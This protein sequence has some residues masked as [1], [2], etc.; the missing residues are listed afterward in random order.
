MHSDPVADM[1]T[2]IRNAYRARL[3]DVGIPHSK[4]LER[5]AEILHREGF[6]GA[7]TVKATEGRPQDVLH[8]ELRYDT[9]RLAMISSI[10]RISRPGLRIYFPCDDIPKIRN[11]LGIVILTTSRGLMTDAEARRARI[12]GEALCSVW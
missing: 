9:D 8:V 12:G 6:V 2:R 10:D 1:L 5:I 7:Y 4:L 3:P 11:G